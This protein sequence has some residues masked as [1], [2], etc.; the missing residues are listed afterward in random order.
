MSSTPIPTPVNVPRQQNLSM[1]SP[2]PP[3]VGELNYIQTLLAGVINQTLYTS[4]TPTFAGLTLSG[5]TPSLPVVT[6]AN[7]VLVSLSYTTFKT[8]L[9][10]AQA[11]I[12]GLKTSDSPT[13]TGLTLGATAGIL[14]AAAGVVAAATIGTS[15]SYSAPTLNT[16]Q[17]IRTV[18]SPTFQG[19]SLTY[20]G[21][22]QPTINVGATS[23]AAQWS[24]NRGGS[25][26]SWVGPSATNEWNIYTQE[27]IPF[28][29]AL[30]SLEV[31]RITAA[32]LIN[33]KATTSIG[34]ANPAQTYYL[35]LICGSAI[36]A[37]RALT[38]TTGDYART[39]TLSGNPTLADW[40]DQGV[41][42]ASTP[43]FAAVKLTTSPA[44][45][46]VWTC[47][48]VDGGGDWEAAGGSMVYP[49]AGVPISTGAAWGTSVT[50]DVS[51]ARKFLRELSV[52]G[53]FTTPVWDTLAQADVTGLHTADS[54]T[55]AGATIGSL[56]GLITGAAGVLGATALGAADLKLF[57]NAAGTGIEWA[58]G[59]NVI[60]FT[61]DL[62][63]SGTQAVTGVGFKPFALFFI[64]G[65]GTAGE[66]SI[67][68]DNN[69]TRGCTKQWPGDKDFYPN[70][71]YSIVM[72][73]A[74]GNETSGKITSLDTDGFTITWT[75]TSGAKTGTVAVS[76]LCFR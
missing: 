76:T 35:R 18:D 71:A 34:L 57:M 40:F 29:M 10:L 31:L 42:A 38:L 55:F 41:K 62:S 45:G 13:F 56:A 47:S 60:T 9:A 75:K 20:A 63:V 19:L 6:D 2:V 23:R 15:L 39:I 70:T 43:S 4:S 44:V 49:G 52:A 65:T 8:N 26:G 54:P 67:G 66:V 50:N 32:G 61:H 27:N 48:N 11:D 64:G 36:T 73:D 12:T 25:T 22:L 17:G 68:Y 16:I 30:N 14:K 59:I 69:T 33:P 58:R 72:T 51:N 3:G 24:M 5:L 37:D 21:S 74:V 7:K 1:M 53:V 28:V 46:K